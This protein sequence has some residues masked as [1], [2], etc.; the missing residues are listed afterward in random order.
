MSSTS[1]VSPVLLAIDGPI[2]RIT[3]NR[4]A[5]LNAMDASMVRGWR[6]ALHTV[7][8]TAGV[9]VLLLRGAGRA[10]MAGGDLAFFRHDAVRQAQDLIPAAHDCL[11]LMGELPVPVVASLRGAV[12]GAGVSVA[13][14]ADLAIAAE[15]TRFTLAYAKVGASPDLG[16]TWHLPQIVGQRKAME[17]ALLADPLNA[18]DALRLSLVNR[19][20]PTDA[21]EVHT[22]ALLQRL[23][24]GP[25]VAY[26]RIRR[27]LRDAGQRALSAQLDAE[28]AAFEASAS[29]ED[30]QEGIAAFLD[31]RLPHF[32]G[33]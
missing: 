17:I 31:K 27:L 5:V 22:D 2:A 12:A 28:Q 25:T 4:P 24:D 29:S 19:V 8:D 16:A 7:R 26:G 10:F 9:R 1:I 14:A 11:R 20:V 3:F 18:Q 13:L 33:R 32:L 23:A 6:D 21:L 15:D 30:F